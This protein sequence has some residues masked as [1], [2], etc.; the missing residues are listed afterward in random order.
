MTDPDIS[1]PH[2]KTTETFLRLYVLLSQFLDR[3]LD[4]AARASLSEQD[5]QHHLSE[6]HTNVGNLLSTNR[7]VKGKVEKEYEEC[8]NSGASISKALERRK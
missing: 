2:I 8:C 5:F 6:T 7:V 3:C 1:P 4:D